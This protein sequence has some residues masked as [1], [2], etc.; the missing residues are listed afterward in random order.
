MGFLKYM[1]VMLT[2][3]GGPAGASILY[4][5]TDDLCIFHV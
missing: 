3:C 1:D 5:G 2:S 4:C